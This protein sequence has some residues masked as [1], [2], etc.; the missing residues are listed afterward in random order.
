MKGERSFQP[1]GRGTSGEPKEWLRTI[2]PE[3]VTEPTLPQ[4]PPA[5]ARDERLTILLPVHNEAES[6]E[7]VLA[8]FWEIVV[9]PLSAEI[10]IC[11][12]GS[13]DGT[14]LVLQQLGRKY[15]LRFV[16]GT[17]R[18]GYAGAVRD[19]LEQVRTPR[20]F[21]ADSDGQYYP[22]DFW[23]LW[24]H[25]EEYDMVVGRK[26]NRDEPSHRLLLSW[27]FHLLAK[28]MTGVPLRDMDCGFRILKRDLV[29]TI[30][31][32]VGVL[33][34]S[35]W[36]EFTILAYKKGIRILEV[37]VSHRA[38][39]RG[40]TS[41]YQWHRIPAIVRSQFR[42]LTELARKLRGVEGRT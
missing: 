6:I 37:P 19:G 2:S 11:E 26:T 42:G 8:G 22:E 34:F 16:N 39:F 14:D 33:P 30:L 40:D 20:I 18:K 5:L 24:P 36:A 32:D 7:R 21:F 38:R 28:I 15:S 9:R 23:K 25:L 10:L 12:D 13:T 17:A 4:G 1:R 29:N 31:P 27:G 41:I 3:A 35:F